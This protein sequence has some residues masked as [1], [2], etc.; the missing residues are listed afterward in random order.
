M[1]RESLL[2]S[3]R[4][5]LVETAELLV[6]EIVTNALVH[7]GTT[8]EVSFTLRDGGLRVE[9]TDGS[10]HAPVRRGYGPN[11]GTGRG[12]MLLEEMV[13]DWGVITAQQGKT[14]WFQLTDEGGEGGPSGR[15]RPAGPVEAGEGALEVVLRHVPLLLHEAWRQHAE[16]LLREYLLTSL[17]LEDGEDPIGVH[18]AASD[19]IAL[20]AEHVPPSGVEDDAEA[21]MVTATDPGMTAEQVRV[22][23]PPGSLAHFE[24]LDSTIEAALQMADEGRLLTPHTQPEVQALRAWL[25]GEVR[26]QAAGLDPVPW[27]SLDEPPLAVPHLLRWDTDVVS[28]ADRGVVAVD[29]AD[30]IVAVSRAALDLLGYRHEDDLV[31]TRLVAIIPERYRQ[32]HLAGFTMHFLSGRA[33]LVGRTLTVPALRGDGREVE[34]AL[35]IGTDRTTDG[36][37]VFVADLEPVTA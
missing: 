16:S 31:G 35:T 25:C 26:R 21:I 13:D 7:A 33:P 17:D 8:I 1:I 11:A 28:R 19:A 9:V 37:T 3:G 36:R 4:E 27:S 20:L 29:D 5:D 30:R 2:Q 14:V 32:A 22:P 23:V 12:L 6:S 10:P 18:A 15:S 34:V 24:T